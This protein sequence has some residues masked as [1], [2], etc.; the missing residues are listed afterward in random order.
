[1]NSIYDRSNLQQDLSTAAG[2]GVLGGVDK[3]TRTGIPANIT[4]PFTGLKVP[5]SAETGTK[6]V[7]KV[8]GCG[9]EVIVSQEALRQYFK[10]D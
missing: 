4:D 8:T 10:E 2:R 9:S 1:M 3:P 5:L 7:G 6:L